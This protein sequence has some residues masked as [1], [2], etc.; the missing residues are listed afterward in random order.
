MEFKNRNII[1]MGFG[2]SALSIM[3]LAG[4]YFFRTAI[5]LRSFPWEN[6]TPAVKNLE[7]HLPT[8]DDPI[9]HCLSNNS[10]DKNVI[11]IIGDSHAA[12]LVPSIKRSIANKMLVKYLTDRALV[13]SIFGSSDCGGTKCSDNEY[14]SRL[15]FFSDNLKKGDIVLFSMARDRIYDGSIDYPKERKNSILKERLILLELKLRNLGKLINKK[16]STLILVDDIPKLCDNFDIEMNRNAMNP[17]PINK[18]VSILD[19]QP[20]TNVYLSLK[21]IGVK[22]V[23]PHPILCPDNT[24]YALYDGNLLYTDSSPHF[25]EFN[26]TPLTNLFK[27]TFNEIQYN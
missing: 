19:R 12:N 13:L 3:I 7:C 6:L 4:A 1:F 18:S 5:L 14:K 8:C 10:Q 20:L 25:A 11:Y 16:K 24:C 9:S 26:S 22:Y 23:D 15:D 21:S 27:V 2:A 17:C